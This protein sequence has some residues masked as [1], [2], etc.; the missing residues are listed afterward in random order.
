MKE[1][2]F[3][4]GI[5]ID[6]LEEHMNHLAKDGFEIVTGEIQKIKVEGIPTLLVLMSRD[7][8]GV[9]SK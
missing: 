7:N 4:G 6:H 8:G 2:I 5:R 1:Y 3:A 9:G